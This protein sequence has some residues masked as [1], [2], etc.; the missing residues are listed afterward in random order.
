MA[1]IIWISYSVGCILVRFKSLKS[2]HEKSFKLLYI[3]KCLIIYQIHIML[4]DITNSSIFLLSFFIYSI[5]FRHPSCLRIRRRYSAR[6][7][8]RPSICSRRFHQ[9]SGRDTERK[10][11]KGRYIFI[12][13]ERE[14]EKK[15]R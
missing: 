8:R 13:R 6:R 4:Y 7:C 9:S 2:W 11:E 12:Y 5:V 14:R 15:D 10:K 1:I 3:S